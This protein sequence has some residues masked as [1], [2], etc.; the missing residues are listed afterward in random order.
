MKAIK[1]ELKMIHKK[2]IVLAADSRKMIEESL[3]TMLQAEKDLD[4]TGEELLG[5]VV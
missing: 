4:V 5:I 2:E 3:K 1:Y